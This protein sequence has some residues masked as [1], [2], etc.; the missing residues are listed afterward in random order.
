MPAEKEKK[1]LA[2]KVGEHVVHPLRG[3]T[4]LI[5]IEEKELEGKRTTYYTLSMEKNQTIWVPVEKAEQIGLRPVISRQA[6]GNI[7][8]I[9]KSEVDHLEHDLRTRQAQ[10]AARLTDRSLENITR[11]VRDLTGRANERKLNE[12]D[13]NTLRRM[14]GLVIG[15]WAVACNISRQEAEQQL[16]EALKKPPPEEPDAEPQ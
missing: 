11:L 12:S 2:F 3:V 15:E 5:A 4:E 9:L 13:A 8:N 7:I 14:K 10:I 6:L 16:E 1:E